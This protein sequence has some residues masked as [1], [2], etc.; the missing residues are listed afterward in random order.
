MN[1]ATLGFALFLVVVV[2]GYWLL[3]GRVRLWWLL[4]ASL[5]FFATWNVVYVPGFMLLIVV[6]YVLGIAAAGDH[7]RRATVAAIGIDLGVL[8][9]F[10]YLDFAIG[11]GAGLF[12][13]LSGSAV[14]FGALGFILPLGISF[15]T[16]TLIAY[17]VD[18]HRGAAPERDLLAFAVF[19]TFFAKAI[20]GPIMRGHQFLPQLRFD[21]RF[22]LVLVGMA[23]PLLVSGLLKKAM[24]DQ[25]APVVRGGFDEMAG[26]SSLALLAM[27]VAFTFQLYLDFAGYTDLARGSA[28]LMGLGLPRNFDWAYRSR[29]MIEFWRRWHMTLG[30]WLRDYLYFPLGGSRRGN[31]YV[32][33]VITMGLAGLWHGAGLTFVVWGLLQG[34]ALAINRWWRLRMS[35]FV[36]PV[37]ATWL[38]TFAFIV[39]VRVFFVAPD[40]GAAIDYLVRALSFQHGQQPDLVLLAVLGGGVVLQWPGWVRLGSSMAPRHTVRRVFA[41]GVAAAVAILLLPSG[42]TE[43][44]YQ[45]F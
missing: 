43:F 14:D 25:L 9:L 7:G 24:A 13:Q 15:L 31:A 19:T 30:T 39:L 1:L 34:V 40:L 28:R 18:V 33:L 4:G 36:L 20:A 21:R 17:V 22:S 11:G 29:S 27:A 5:L 26:L 32:N 35:R 45:N 3:R 42:Q 23:M 44:I 38:V 10:K 37:L 12:A 2:A 6:N 16:F 8:G 41:Y